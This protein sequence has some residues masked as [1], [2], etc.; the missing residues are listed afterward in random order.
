MMSEK[1]EKEENS[2]SKTEKERIEKHKTFNK[3]QTPGV[4]QKNG[5]VDKPKTCQRPPKN[6]R[7]YQSIQT[8]N[9]NRKKR[10]FG[11]IP[12]TYEELKEKTDAGVIP[13]TIYYRACSNS[14]FIPS[15]TAEMIQD[16]GTDLQVQSSSN[17]YFKFARVRQ[18]TK[19]DHADPEKVFQII[20]A[21]Q[22]RPIIWDQRLFCHQNMLLV[23]RAWQQLDLELGFDEEY[24]L[25]RRKKIWKSKKD[26]FSYAFNTDSLSKWIFTRA[27]EFYQPMVN[28]RT[29]VCLRPTVSDT[30][31]EEST[32]I[33]LRDKLVL[34]DKN[35][36][37][38]PSDK[39]NV[40][41]FLLKSLYE[42]GMT[43][44]K[45]ME[46]HGET[47]LK[48]FETNFDALTIN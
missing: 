7:R 35:V 2:Y 5:S 37:C 3:E 25:A 44:P 24:P 1:I 13:E 27:M 40:L 10:K 46:K 45:I 26:Y 14:M 42:T 47:I 20:A 32:S 39:E 22:K 33:N 28:F 8:S 34:A 43:D 29:T 16:D 30:T 4:D 31:L 17:E 9:N 41:T 23:R 12:T 21:V 11:H 36:Q 48:I 15:I 38:T 18:T 19:N 6:A